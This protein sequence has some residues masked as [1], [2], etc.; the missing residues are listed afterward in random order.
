MKPKLMLTIGGSW[1]APNDPAN[2]PAIMA[3]YLGF[4]LFYIVWIGWTS[5]VLLKSPK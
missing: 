2:L 4:V 5:V 1:T 3:T